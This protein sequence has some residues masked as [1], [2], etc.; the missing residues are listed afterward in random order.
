MLQ[1]NDQ[2]KI[3]K[4]S[5]SGEDYFV[6][7]QM[8]LPLIG[9]D[10]FSLYIALN[11]MHS[12]ESSNPILA[13]KLLDLLN[14]SNVGLLENA[15]YKLEGIGLVKRYVSE[16]TSGY[17]FEMQ[18]PLDAK[19]F[20]NNS[21]LKNY[22]FSQ[23]GEVQLKNL[24]NMVLKNKVAG[25]KEISKRF[26]EI[27]KTGEKK[28]N[29]YVDSLKRDLKDNIRVKNDKFDYT[30]F[31]L[32]FD[33]EFLDPAVLD[34]ETFEQ[35]I[36]R[37]SYQ[38]QLNEKEM[39]EAVFKTITIGNDL[40]FTDIS[41][42][43]GYI[44]QNKKIEKPLIFEAKEAV[45][46]NPQM[47]DDLKMMINHFETISPAELLAELSGGKAALSEIKDFEKVAL[48]TGLPDSVI[49]VLITYIVYNK[50]GE[51]P[52]YSYI[53]KIAKTWLRAKI[54]TTAK[55]IEYINKPVEK[56]ASKQY[57]KSEKTNPEW[58]NSYMNSMKEKWQEEDLT[59]EEIDAGLNAGM[60]LFKQDDE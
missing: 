19:S 20:L 14:M 17:Y 31:K 32:M 42:N 47:S 44:Y 41:K 45:D 37:I 40:K 39:Y 48:E 4:I 1:V 50:E 29:A 26:D 56:K 6:L 55:A 51:I 52:S 58:V 57:K 36:L 8:Y 10:S 7:S 33:S 34:D 38:Y 9:M 59:N 30:I 27:Y 28:S 35:E 5:L 22:L 25:Y 46:Y 54:N 53:E 18:A 23:I 12:K 21:L 2:I 13:S 60:K 15:F 3:T 43:A 49:N 16:R 24:K 11:N